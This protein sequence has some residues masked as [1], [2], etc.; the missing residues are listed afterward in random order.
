MSDALRAAEPHKA[1]PF[2]IGQIRVPPG[3]RR[4]IRLKISEMYTTS[5]VFIPLTVVNGAEPGPRLA[6][7]AAIHGN[8]LNGVEMVRQ[9]RGEVDAK[10]L[11]GT[12]LLVPIANPIA[13]MNMNR[14]LPD[15]RDLNRVFPG[16]VEGSIASHIARSLFQK[17]IRRADFGVDLHTAATGRT[18][19][20]HVRADMKLKSVNRLAC[21]FGCEIIF[22]MAG[23]KGMLRRAATMAGVP[24]IVYEAGEPLK[25]QQPLIRQ[26]VVGIKNVM[27][28][29]GMYDFPRTSP[30]FQMVVDERGWIRAS[31]GGI[32]ILNVKPGDIIKKGED[33][34]VMSKPYGSEVHRLKAP[35]TGLVVGCTT[36]P[37]ALPGSAIVNLVKLGA[38][39]RVL[40]KLLRRQRVL[41]E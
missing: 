35:Y 18:N 33:I 29:L 27:G 10:R 20:P 30:P 3:E 41:F 36:I 1:H 25:F 5:P 11:K 22:D 14:D 2:E 23:E 12:L 8:E 19:L 13:F 28:E 6:V 26:G 40:S 7:I 9:I 39:H 24:M 17:V 32:M 4:E 15:G 38:R 34:C 37:M 21:A 16:K 31:K